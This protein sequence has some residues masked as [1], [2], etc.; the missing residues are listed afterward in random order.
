MHRQVTAPTSCWVDSKLSHFFLSCG[1]DRGVMRAVWEHAVEPKPGGEMA[2]NFNDFCVAVRCV[3]AS[4]E[5]RALTTYLLHPLFLP[6]FRGVP[7]PIEPPPK[8]HPVPVVPLAM[9]Q[10]SVSAAEHAFPKDGSAES[11]DGWDDN[12]DVQTAEGALSAES[13]LAPGASATPAGDAAMLRDSRN[14]LGFPLQSAFQSASTASSE[15]PAVQDSQHDHSLPL[16]NLMSQYFQAGP[17]AGE[18]TN[19]HFPHSDDGHANITTDDDETDDWGGFEAGPSVVGIVSPPAVV[20]ANSED[21]EWGEFGSDPTN[22]LG[23]TASAA[24]VSASEPHEDE[25]ADF[26]DGK[27]DNPFGEAGHEIANELSM[28]PDDPIQ[29]ESP[30]M[31]GH[32][33]IGRQVTSPNAC[34]EEVP[35]SLAA[36]SVN[37]DIV[38]QPSTDINEPAVELEE[39]DPFALVHDAVLM[40][41]TGDEVKS[42]IEPKSPPVLHEWPHDSAPDSVFVHALVAR[43]RFDEALKL[44]AQAHIDQEIAVLKKAIAE[45]A[46]NEDFET[47]IALRK[48]RDA[49]LENAASDEEKRSWKVDCERSTTIHDMIEELSACGQF[50]DAVRSFEATFSYSTAAAVATADIE[51]LIDLKARARESFALLER[52]TTTH[53]MHATFYDWLEAS[54][55][56]EVTL[57]EAIALDAEALGADGA[58]SFYASSECNDFFK[59]LSRALMCLGRVCDARRKSFLGGPECIMACF[60]DV[61]APA[62]RQLLSSLSS[63]CAQEVDDEAAELTQHFCEICLRHHGT[64]QQV[65]VGK[66]CHVECGAWW[67]NRIQGAL[68]SN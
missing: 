37:E 45:A 14:S 15:V 62:L 5:G 67:L 58:S 16:E 8:P 63:K 32:D 13:V 19:P 64:V 60:R 10:D 44:L 42:Q 4:M 24:T 55:V 18:N 6:R 38:H 9:P 3:A 23:G 26:D 35:D 48:K 12:N 25:W 20:Q 59:G 36:V 68:P 47:A 21:D 50:P 51:K 56:E 28:P 22:S 52:L 61:K 30:R 40:G 34:G 57:F 41:A 33:V 43:E 7:A 17:S 11:L 31:S 54:V 1:V 66:F 46:M 49:M 2:M 53:Q 39:E 65:A 27:G 29:H